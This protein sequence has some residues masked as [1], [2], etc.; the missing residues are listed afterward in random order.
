MVRDDGYVKVLDF[1]LARV[2][3]AR[4]AERSDAD[5][6]NADGPRARHGRLHVAGAGARRE[7][8]ARQR[9]LRLRHHPL[10]DADRAAS[11]PRQRLRSRCCTASCR[12]RRSRRREWASRSR[13][14]S[15]SSRSSACRRT[16][17]C[18]RRPRRWRLRLRGNEP[19]S[20]ARRVASAH[21]PAAGAA[22]PRR[23]RGGVRDA[24]RG[25][26]RG[27]PAG[28]A[29]SSPSRASLASARRRSSKTA[30]ACWPHRRS[31]HRA[32]ALL[33][34]AGGQRGLPAVPRGARRAA[35]QREHG[36]LARVL[37][38]VAPNWYVQVMSL[39]SNDSS[40]TRVLAE[41]GTGFAAADEARN[42]G[43][44]R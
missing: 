40:A 37:K 33:G 15:T 14:R 26:P 39:P 20:V 31:A 21:R 5:R 44:S 8:H 11:L 19:A 35:A 1:G 34:A 4:R 18:A 10:R 13:W 32:G 43:V 24:H 9:R 38:A 6:S 30:S 29:C 12:T 22:T 3:S 36:N 25:V 7:R 17:A 28:A 2:A 23:S 16:R 27:R 42:G 41:A